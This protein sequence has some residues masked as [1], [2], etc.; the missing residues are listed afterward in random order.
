MKHP[1]RAAFCSIAAFITLSVFATLA[2]AAPQKGRYVRVCI[3]AEGATL[4]LAEVQVFSG[5]KNIAEGKTTCQNSE[6]H[7]GSAARAVDGNTSGNW[8]DGSITHT[9]EKVAEPAWEVD[10]G[11]DFVVEKIVLWNRDGY[12]SRLNGVNVFLLDSDRKAVWGDKAEQPGRGA[13]VFDLAG[14]EGKLQAGKTFDA[15]KAASAPAVVAAKG[16]RK[17]EGGGNK[18]QLELAAE[19]GGVL[20]GPLTDDALGHRMA[21]EGTAESLKMAINDIMKTYGRRRYP[22]GEE[23]LKRI[24]AGEDLAVLRR[25]ALL[26]ENPAIDFERLLLVRAAKNGKRYSSNWQTRTSCDGESRTAN[27]KDL[28]TVR[29]GL[30]DADKD[31]SKLLSARKKAEKAHKQAYDALLNSDEYKNNKKQ[32]K[33]MED[34]LP[35]AVALKAAEKALHEAGMKHPEYAGMYAMIR[36]KTPIANYEDTLITLTLR[37]GAIEEVYK[38]ASGKFIGDVD[39]HFEADKVLFTS[40]IPKEKL[41]NVSGRGQGYGVFEIGIDPASGKSRGAPVWVSPDMDSD[42]DCYDACYLPDDKHIIYASTAA[43]EGV[44]CVGGGSYVANLYSINREDKSVRRLTFDQDGNWHPC[45]MENGRVMFTRWEYTDSAHYFSRILMSM[46]PDGTDQKAYYGSNSYWPNSMFYARPLPGKPGMF[47]AT[48][49]G[50]HSNAKGGAL[51]VFDVTKGRHEADGA[52]QFLTGHGKKV[53]PL[54]IDGLHRVYSPMFYNPYP[55]TDK[56]FLATSANGDV[57]LL[58]IYDNVICLKQNDGAGKYFEPVPLRKTKRPAS[59]PGTVDLTSKEATV[60]INDV[61]E[62]PGLSGVPRGT[63][64][65]L[66]IY[67]YEYGPRHKGGHYA[68]GMEAGWDAKQVLGIANVEEDGSASFKVPANTP[69]AIQPLDAEGRALQLMRSWTAAMPGEKLTCIGC[70][71]N[72]NMTPP[73]KRFTA[74]N[75]QPDEL[76]PFYGPTRGFS[77]QR[78]VQPVIDKF[79]VCCHDGKEPNGR[80]EIP[81]RVIGTGPKTG[82]SLK[83]CG[84]PDFSDPRNAHTML[85]PYVRRNGPEGDYHLLTPLEFHTTTSELF[86]MLDKGHHNVKLDADSMQRLITW[87][88]L[89]APV[90]GTWTEA[91]ASKEILDRRKEL[92]AKYAGVIY[93]PEEIVNPYEKSDEMVMPAPLERKVVKPEPPQCGKPQQAKVELDLGGDVK[94]TL[95]GIPP[96]EFSMGSNCETPQEQPVSRV[97][98]D[99]GFLMG[100][101]EVTLEQYRQFDPDYLN[102]VYDMHYKDQVHRGYYMNDMDYPVIRVPWARAVEF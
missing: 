60:L 80:Y 102:G 21:G 22:K 81:D 59:I 94:M 34:N 51:C 90:H 76:K 96:G 1:Y 88:D 25:E 30:K 84:I 49:T 58:D 23:F 47:V 29:N 18:S 16:G 77:F 17:S 19:N 64:R 92:R 15:L 48:I 37:D 98:I 86:Q 52:I 11:G 63:V 6:A 55:I 53:Y 79:C 97:K 70:H 10:L 5:G 45:V 50:H 42:L 87:A 65:S 101:T 31:L 57:Y 41:N 24:E 7:G 95:V 2:A 43:Y 40:F 8:K 74:M 69:F 75:R 72:Q 67:R 13:T 83:E 4:S 33:Q 91:G 56:F 61:Y 93:D 66:R 36:D 62:G 39:L 82:K 89:N 68:M 26:L 32:R 3:P 20:N 38:P 9:R 12:E 71:E 54:V 35:E 14:T 73:V 85:H 99:K 78:E 28:E 46:N 100:A 44:P 27:A